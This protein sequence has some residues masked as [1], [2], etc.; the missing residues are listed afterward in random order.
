MEEG[1]ITTFLRNTR[2]S[3]QDGRPKRKDTFL[4][5]ANWKQDTWSEFLGK[6]EEKRKSIEYFRVPQHRIRPGRSD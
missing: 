4:T 6:E 2:I 5:K 3:S 1:N